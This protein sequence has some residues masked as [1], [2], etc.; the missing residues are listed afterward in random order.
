M[1]CISLKCDYDQEKG[2]E[3]LYVCKGSDAGDRIHNWINTGSLFVEVPGVKDE[4][5]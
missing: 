4:L 5:A 1:Y 2:F 3:F